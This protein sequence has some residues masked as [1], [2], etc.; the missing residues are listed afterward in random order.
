[1]SPTL[2]T[3]IVV[4]IVILEIVRIAMTTYVLAHLLESRALRRHGEEAGQ[5]VRS[6]R[7]ARRRAERE[8][9]LDPTLTAIRQAMDDVALGRAGQSVDRAIEAL[10]R[11]ALTL[12]EPGERA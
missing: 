7:S 9:L 4:V 1:M 2:W 8:A 3:G 6:L 12:V 5:G 10:D 11:Y